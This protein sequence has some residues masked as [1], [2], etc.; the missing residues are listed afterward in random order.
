MSGPI[1]AAPLAEDDLNGKVVVTLEGAPCRF[2]LQGPR[3]PGDGTVPAESGQAPKPHARQIFRHEG[4][5]KG[6]ES[7]DHQ[8][9]F[10]ARE[11]LAVTLYSIAKIAAGSEWFRAQAEK[12]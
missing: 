3:G 11:P 2:D 9:A 7:Y 4:T 5:A 1:E 12:S 8:K 10:D 6:H